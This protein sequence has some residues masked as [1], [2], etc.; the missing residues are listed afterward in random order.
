MEYH[1]KSWDQLAKSSPRRLFVRGSSVHAQMSVCL[2][3]RRVY[4]LFLEIL[5]LG[6]LAWLAFFKPSDH[7]RAKPKC[8]LWAGQQHWKIVGRA[9]FCPI[10][11]MRGEKKHSFSGTCWHVALRLSVANKY[12]RFTPAVLLLC[13]HC[14][15]KSC[16]SSGLSE[17]TGWPSNKVFTQTYLIQ[18]Y[19]CTV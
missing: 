13:Q 12:A 9:V 3:V 18:G 6:F 4:R 2:P 11:R 17:D 16:D 14:V 15:H 5:R 10:C 8:Q 7:N 1:G 19:R